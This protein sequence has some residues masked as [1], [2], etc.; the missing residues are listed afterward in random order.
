MQKRRPKIKARSTKVDLKKLGPKTVSKYT[1]KKNLDDFIK[2]F[3]CPQCGSVTKH[4][5]GDLKKNFKI[6][7]FTCRRRLWERT[8]EIVEV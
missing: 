7:C 6:T 2:S 5:D 4:I 3:R 8:V 1:N